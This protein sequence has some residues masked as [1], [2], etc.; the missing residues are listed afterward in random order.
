LIGLATVIYLGVRLHQGTLF[1]NLRSPVD[2]VINPL[3]T[4]I[5]SDPGALAKAIQVNLNGSRYIDDLSLIGGP[6]TPPRP[7]KTYLL[8]NV[9]VTYSGGGQVRI[10]DERWGLVSQDKQLYRSTAF[11]YTP[12]DLRPLG[13]T[14]LGGGKTTGDLLFEVDKA[15]VP[16]EIRYASVY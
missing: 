6:A 8:C 7:G 14:L 9:T 13:A 10:T 2:A 15:T 12:R 5:A 16:V 11:W 4:P 1:S 3:P